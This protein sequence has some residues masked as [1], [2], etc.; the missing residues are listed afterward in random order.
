MAKADSATG[1]PQAQAQAQAIFF[2]AWNN[3]Q[4]QDQ[5]IVLSV[6]PG[7]YCQIFDVATL[8]KVVQANPGRSETR[9]AQSGN[10]LLG[11]PFQ[12]GHS[13]S[14]SARLLGLYAHVTCCQNMLNF[15]QSL[16]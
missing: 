11:E 10:S 13:H 16:G 15:A 4:D 7:L 1:K 9:G 3:H 2:H 6:S 5:N 12:P 14:V 8:R